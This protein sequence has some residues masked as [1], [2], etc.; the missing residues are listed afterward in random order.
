MNSIRSFNI[1]II[2]ITTA[3]LVACGGG[4]DS[5][6]PTLTPTPIP[7]IVLQ[8]SAGDLSK[9]TN[10]IFRSGCGSGFIGTTPY[11]GYATFNFGTATTA[12][13]SGVYNFSPAGLFSC[14]GGSSVLPQTIHFTMT[15]VGTTTIAS[16][17]ASAS[18]VA[19]V[20]SFR[21]NVTNFVNVQTFAFNSAYSKLYVSNANASFTSSSLSHD[22]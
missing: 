7:P 3:L 10:A 15:Y 8:A 2:A 22:R 14:T 12:L 6:T 20:F 4:G 13:V 18:G 16:S 19:D 5:S 11:S 17:N 9:Y 21:N 1:A